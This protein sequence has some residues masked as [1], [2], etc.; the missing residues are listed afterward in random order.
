MTRQFQARTGEASSEAQ[1]KDETMQPEGDG[2]D[3]LPIAHCTLDRRGRILDGNLEAASLFG[4]PRAELIGEL[5]PSVVTIVEQSRFADHLARCFTTGTRN[6]VELTLVTWRGRVV[7]E[8]ISVPL[9]GAD[10]RIFAVIS[11]LSDVTALKMSEERL[12][13]LSETSEALVSSLDYSTTLAMVTRRLVPAVADMAFIDVCEDDGRIARYTPRAARTIVPLPDSPQ[14]CV[15]ESGQPML[16]PACGEEKLALALSD[17]GPPPSTSKEG[18]LLLVPLIARERILGVLTCVITGSGRYHSLAD[19]SLAQQV[20]SRAAMAVDNARLYFSARRAIRAREDVAAIVSHDLRNP[21]QAIRLYCEHML[22]A[23]DLKPAQM[24][25]H[26]EAVLR[27]VR[28]MDRL[29]SDLLDM[30]RI[31]AGQLRIE[32]SDNEAAALVFEAVNLVR[33]LAE[34]KGIAL[35]VFIDPRS[36]EIYCDRE[37]MLQVLSNL[38]GN[39][40]K[41]TDSGGS[42][43]VAVATDEAWTTLAVRDTGEGIPPEHLPHLFD[44]Y[45]RASQTSN[46]GVGL[47]LFIAKAI[48]DAH[49]GEISVESQLGIGTA[50]TVRLPRAQTQRPLVTATA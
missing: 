27:G 34:H 35:D 48:V 41:F 17:G 44:R 26:V 4:W 8:M 40:I 22:S 50:V 23:P 5:L 9:M 12:R 29:I 33:P 28:S 30:S 7:V 37:R 45:W 15:L 3:L 24:Q 47:G 13:I 2:Q 16:H 31:E 36:E 14:S 43:S 6:N 38:L 39:A 20:A 25:Q 19:L 32:E 10:G 46:K 18:S 1:A 42:I 21:L 11:T 49:E